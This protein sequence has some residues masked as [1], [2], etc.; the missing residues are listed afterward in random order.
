MELLLLFLV[1]S[2]TT[3]TL[4]PGDTMLT[5][6]AWFATPTLLTLFHEFTVWLVAHYA[7]FGLEAYALF[8]FFFFVHSLTHSYLTRR[9]LLFSALYLTRWVSPRPLRAAK[10]TYLSEVEFFMLETTLAFEGFFFL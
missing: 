5:L 3:A 6:R 8:R 9:H 1:E 10:L 2:C 4:R 7:I